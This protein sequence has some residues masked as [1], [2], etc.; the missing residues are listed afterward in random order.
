MTKP[1]HQSDVKL[2][3]P[4][5]PPTEVLPPIAPPV[6]SP[7]S[8][9]QPTQAAPRAATPVPVAWRSWPIVDSLGE[10]FF[11]TIS[12]GAA[13][14]AAYRFAGPLTAIAAA[15]VLTFV[16]WR[17]F[18][19]TFFELSALGVSENCL[20]RK[21]RIPWISIDRYVVGRKGA[22]LSS[23]GAPLELLRGLYLPWGPHREQI[24]AVLRYYLPRAEDSAS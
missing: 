13:I 2:A 7:S 17:Y 4:S 12:S 24:V 19:P 18:V 23:A 5:T 3:E 10:F 15:V 22:Y 6:T 11:L 16:S 20:G 1:S 8:G 21:R 14:G 9:S